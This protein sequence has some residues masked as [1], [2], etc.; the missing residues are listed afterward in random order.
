MDAHRKTWN[1][2]QK[3]LRVLLSDAANFE[4]AI[5]LFLLQHSEVHSSAMSSVG[6][7]SFVDEVLDGL[8][9]SHLRE[10]PD[11]EEHSIAWT[12]WHLARIEDVT[13]NILVAGK[14]QLFDREGWGTALGLSWRHTGNA[15]ARAEIA[16]LSEKLDLEALTRYR[17][18]VGINTQHIAR[19][20]VAD[21]IQKGVA[22]S[23]LEQLVEI[24][25]VQDRAS[26]LL[27]YWGRRTIAGL[28]LMPPTRHC[29]IHLNEANRIRSRI[30]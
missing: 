1:D 7:V 2:R 16:E 18:A 6:D 24:G 11:R 8:E 20:L 25:A 4:Q 30:V 15:M 9:D 27:E 22:P 10:L 17:R 19:R 23:R 12:L 3:E 29:F 28:L 13:M 21:D 26:G 5:R 14:R